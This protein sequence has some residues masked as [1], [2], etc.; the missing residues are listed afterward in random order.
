MASKS[1]TLRF[2][3]TLLLIFVVVSAVSAET[4]EDGAFNKVLND[5]KN[6]AHRVLENVG[7]E[8]PEKK[9]MEVTVTNNDTDEP[10]SS[11]V[12][13]L[14]D[15]LQSFS[16]KG[17]LH[18]GAADGSSG[19]CASGYQ[20]Y[21]GTCYRAYGDRKSYDDAKAKCAADGG[22]L[23]APK[24][25]RL[26]TFIMGLVQ[27]NGGGDHWIGLDDRASEGVWTFS[28]GTQMQNCDFKK[29]AP[30]EPN[31]AGGQDC[32]QYWAGAGNRWDDDTCSR[33]KKFICQIG[34]GDNTGCTGTN[35]NSP[36]YMSLGCWK[37]KSSRAIGLLEG[38]DS[39]LNADYK[40]RNNA[41][42]KCYQVAK[43]RG[44]MVFGVQN[45]GQCFGSPIA[46]GTYRKYGPSSG[47]RGG[48]GGR[49]ANDVYR[50]TDAN[51]KYFT[52]G[53]WKDT[54]SRAIT[55]VEG[56]DSR[57]DGQYSRRQDAINKCYEVAK[58]KGNAVFS[59]QN[60]GQC[61]T[62]SNAQSTYY[63]FGRST[64]CKTDGKGGG[65]ANQVYRIIGAAGSGGTS[66][67]CASGY[68]RYEG[69]CYRAYGDR[70]SY[71]DAKAKCAADGGRLVA[72]KTEMLDTFIM[73]LVQANGGGDHWIGLD[74][75]A[76]E[77][78]WTF[79]DGTQMQNCD[80]KKWAPG[81][82]NNAGGQDCVQYWAGAGN[83]WDDDT[84]SRQKK[85]IC[86]I[87]PGDNTGCTGTQ[88]V[89]KTDTEVIQ[90]PAPTCSA[91]ANI[92]LIVDGS[93]SVTHLNFPNVLK[94]V[95]KL[96]AG[97]EIGPNA[98][99][100]GVY[101]YGSDLRTELPIGQYNT[102][103]DVLN[104]VRKIQYMNQWG[105]FTGKAL[106]EAYKEFPAGDDA[107]K[108]VIIITDG[109]AMDREVLRKAAQDVKAD[110]AMICAVGVGGFVLKEITLLASS[111]DLVFTA[112]DFDQMDAIRDA[113]LDSVCEGQVRR[114]I[115][116]EIDSTLQ[117]L[118]ESAVELVDNL[119]RDIEEDEYVAV[120]LKE[121]L[122]A[123]FGLEARL[124]KRAENEGSGVMEDLLKLGNQLDHIRDIAVPLELKE[125]PEF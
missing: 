69:T 112:T 101:Q 39:R 82:P 107:K 124:E 34:P 58:A 9:S 90:I 117:F 42:G 92:I 11:K 95:L 40:R 45:G 30:G 23:V 78:V 14:L 80:F 55:I 108:I 67:S 91:K 102:R 47:C 111:Q 65:W 88:T 51:P 106:E 68:Q 12:L 28:D 41:L 13:S 49:W 97:F 27:A 50:I 7:V 71:D 57:L 61:G 114:D 26:D 3:Q 37:D 96:A 33:Q 59:V 18:G 25:E 122:D 89:T 110:G 70:K 123:L 15:A 8:G 6:V 62:S 116:W 21:D 4:P 20:R 43:D 48:K 56:S 109:K 99:K 121:A 118:K 31:N 100:L 120:Q 105:T 83:R 63:K 94:F 17:F 79:S 74:D 32:V 46:G 103:E 77:G 10:S 119:G 53:C 113:V 64:A 44:F 38:K 72:P 36:G 86:Q 35:G 24:T 104:A 84:C 81:E 54:S 16:K 125:V 75:R 29:W 5:L 60:G 52:L 76:S 2:L 115:A 19:S 22:R 87:G 1:A 93:K 73:G 66:G 85:F 98:A